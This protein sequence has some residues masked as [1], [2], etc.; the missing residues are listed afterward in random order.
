MLQSSS[1]TLNNNGDGILCEYTLN[2][3]MTHTL[4]PLRNL[5][6]IKIDKSKQNKTNI[7]NLK[8]YLVLL[9][10]FAILVLHPKYNDYD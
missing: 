4:Y 8:L 3:C 5:N 7:N 2:S 10:F 1:E 6:S 9:G